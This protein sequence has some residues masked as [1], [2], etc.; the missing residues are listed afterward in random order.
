MNH[1]QQRKPEYIPGDHVLY[2]YDPKKIMSIEYFLGYD[3]WGKEVYMI[4]RRFHISY[5]YSSIGE[6]LLKLVA[7]KIL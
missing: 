6:L 7:R 4:K 5:K 3:S 1:Q 2:S